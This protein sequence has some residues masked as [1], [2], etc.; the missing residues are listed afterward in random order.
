MAR[1]EELPTLKLLIYEY[2]QADQADTSAEN[3][4]RYFLTLRHGT[5]IKTGITLKKISL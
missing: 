2:D 4:W 3:V 5:I 1:I